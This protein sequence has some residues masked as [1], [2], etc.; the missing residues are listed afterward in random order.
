M[1]RSLFYKSRIFCLPAR[2]ATILVP[3]AIAVPVVVELL[4]HDA[5]EGGSDLIGSK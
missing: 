1:D 4:A 3:E 5:G 2:Q